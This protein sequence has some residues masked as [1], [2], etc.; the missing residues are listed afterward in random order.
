MKAPKGQ[1]GGAARNHREGAGGKIPPLIIPVARSRTLLLDWSAVLA[2]RVRVV[3]GCVAALAVA[4]G[5]ASG[6]GQDPMPQAAATSTVSATPGPTIT[7]PPRPELPRG[8]RTLFPHYRLVGYAGRAGSEALGRL[9]I[10]GVDSRAAELIKRA[11]PYSDGREILPVFELIATMATS[12]PTKD[13]RYRVRA[14][15][16]LIDRYLRAARR[17]RALLLLNIQPGRADFL[18]EVRAYEKWLRRPDVGLAL[19]PE[20]AVGDG[21]TPGEVYGN[22]TGTE[23]DA[24]ARYLSRIVTANDLPEKVLV[25]H[26]VASSVVDDQQDLHRHR[27]VVIIKSVDGIGSRG[28]KETTW[29]NLTRGMPRQFH[30]GFKLFF[31]EDR[32]QG[33]LMTPSQVLRL[34]PKPEYVMYE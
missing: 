1:V 32:R 14:D 3:V 21:Q 10:G 20:W 34:R 2:K 6:Q 15:D 19:D 28:A 27:G 12:F 13:G 7:P 4:A 29:R 33:A 30:A 16:G 11:R 9:G 17:H 18:P 24:V 26:Q 8:G 23:L 25:F 5:C 22:T 31:V